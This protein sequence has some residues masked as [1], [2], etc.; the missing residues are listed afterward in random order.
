MKKITPAKQQIRLAISS[1]AGG[2]GKT[3]TAVHLAYLV[4]SKGYKVVLLELDSNGSIAVLGGVS[5]RHPSVATIF[6]REFGGDYPLAPLWGDRL[7]TAF[8]IPGGRPLEETITELYA[9]KRRYYLLSDRLDDYPLDA[10]LI[11]FDTPASLEPMGVMA[12]AASTHVLAPIKPEWKDA[13]ALQGLFLWYYEQIEE[14]RLKPRPEILGFLPTRVD[15]SRAI[16]RNLLGL[17]KEGKENPKID[18]TETLTYQIK[19]IGVP[20]FPPVRETNYY[21]QA[22]RVGLPIHLYQPGLPY[23]Q[24]Y[25]QVVEKIVELMTQD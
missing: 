8:A 10:D 5:P 3:T 14:L 16:H 20:C 15:L 7:N 9:H 25:D 24:D 19:K 12:L 13:G 11:I 18:E 6:S 2:S 22:S 21:L 23:A 4:A 1:N 17:T